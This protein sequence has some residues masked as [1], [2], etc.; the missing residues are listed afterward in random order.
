MILY[1]LKTTLILGIF[2]LLYALFLKNNKSFKWNRM[3][4]LLSSILALI[5]PLLQNISF[6]KK[7]LLTQGAKPLYI[8]LN[9]INI[10]ANSIQHKELDF[11]KLI[12]GI[13]AIG[14]IWGLLRMILGFIVINRIK[15]GSRLEKVDD[16]LIYFNPN[17]ESPFS[18]NS[19]I[20]IPSSFKN[21][22]VLNIIL[23]HEQ[24][25]V[26]LKH[27]R[28]KIYFSLLQALCWFNPF[29]YMY[30]KE[31]ELVHEYEADEFSTQTFSTDDYVE[32]LLQTINYTQTPTLLAHHFFH[33]P[34]KTRIIMLYK[35]S[36][37]ALAQKSLVI[38]AI[39]SICILALFLQS[40]AQKKST[41]NKYRIK[42]Y[43]NDSIFVENPN[44][45][46]ELKITSRA[47]DTLYELVEQMPEFYGGENEL[48]KY[49]GENINYPKKENL[50]R[51][52]GRVVVV[53]SVSE[54]GELYDIE[55]V[56]FPT[57]GQALADEAIRVVKNMPKWKP[58]KEKGKAV[59]VSFALPILFKLN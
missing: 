4:L 41:E 8:T 1:F 47:P 51:I 15:E 59:K 18:F 23:K 27:S 38:I 11:A 37:N 46:I 34:L 3:Y 9:T 42:T 20:Y 57:N 49:L 16:D 32:K 12:L 19:N 55:V 7:G 43:A 56:K 48:A 40:D 22:D 25:H 17:I 10:Y 33:H 13:Y 28:D 31:I 14:L 53:F 52:Q 36:K 6:I 29:V 24:A 2:Y 58:G 21:N 39:L 5:L 26:K 44:G 45:D 50:E 30:H 54:T 35:K